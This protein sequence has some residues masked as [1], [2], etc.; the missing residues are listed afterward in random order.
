M[1]L[2]KT[3]RRQDTSLL[4]QTARTLVLAD[5]KTEYTHDN[6]EF[7]TGHGSEISCKA[8]STKLWA[9]GYLGDGRLGRPLNPQN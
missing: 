9:S 6:G 5:M 1:P 2:Q 4:W 7:G 8:W 3:G